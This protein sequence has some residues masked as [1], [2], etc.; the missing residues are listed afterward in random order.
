[1]NIKK[2][3]GSEGVSGGGSRGSGRERFGGEGW[4]DVYQVLY[5]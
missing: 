1:M 4:A 5:N 2:S 3:R